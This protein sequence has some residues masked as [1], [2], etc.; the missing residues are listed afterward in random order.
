VTHLIIRA[1]ADDTTLK[2]IGHNM[3]TLRHLELYNLAVGYSRSGLKGIAHLESLRTL[4]LEVAAPFHALGTA[5]SGHSS[6]WGPGMVFGAAGL[7]GEVA[8]D[9]SAVAGNLGVPLLGTNAITAFSPP[10]QFNVGVVSADS[11]CQL[12]HERSVDPPLA[13]RLAC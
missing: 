4:I 13:R 10:T 9:L 1:G 12:G 5:S 6:G 11:N 3:T 7:V 2:M 8:G